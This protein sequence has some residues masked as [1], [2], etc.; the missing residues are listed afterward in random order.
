MRII[1][2]FEETENDDAGDLVRPSTGTPYK[3]KN[4]CREVDTTYTHYKDFTDPS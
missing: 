2:E 4:I 3:Y 1:T